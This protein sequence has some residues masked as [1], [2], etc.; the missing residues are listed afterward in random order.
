MS[1]SYANPKVSFWRMW[2]LPLVFI[3]GG[4][5]LACAYPDDAYYTFLEY[6]PTEHATWQPP[7]SVK[8]DDPLPVGEY[9]LVVTRFDHPIES[10]KNATGAGCSSVQVMTL[11]KVV[12]YSTFE[13]S[14]ED[15]TATTDRQWVN[16]GLFPC[17][18]Y[19]PL[20]SNLIGTLDPDHP[21]SQGSFHA[22][23]LSYLL[24]QLVKP[25]REAALPGHARLV[26]I[27]RFPSQNLSQ[28][29]VLDLWNFFEPDT[30]TALDL[31]NLRLAVRHAL[32]KTVGGDSLVVAFAHQIDGATSVQED[33]HPATQV[34]L[35]KERE[36]QQE[37]PKTVNT[38]QAE[39]K[40][41]NTLPNHP[42]SNKFTHSIN[43]AVKDYPDWGTPPSNARQGIRAGNSGMNVL[44]VF[45][46]IILAIVLV[47]VWRKR[48]SQQGETLAKDA[49][50]PAVT[51]RENP[52]S[53][54][55]ALVN[56]EMSVFVDD[57]A[58]RKRRIA[59]DTSF[60]FERL[61]TTAHWLRGRA[62]AIGAWV[63]NVGVST[64][65]IRTLVS[66][67]VAGIVRGS[68]VIVGYIR[69]LWCFIHATIVSWSRFISTVPHLEARISALEQSIASHMEIESGSVHARGTDQNALHT[70]ERAIA[71]RDRDMDQT[72]AR[73][74]HDLNSLE[75][76]VA[77]L[78]EAMEAH[79][80]V[81]SAQPT[82]PPHSQT[83]TLPTV[84]LP[85]AEVR[86]NVVPAFTPEVAVGR[87][88]RELARALL[89]FQEHQG[90]DA[91]HLVEGISSRCE[92]V[93]RW[94]EDILASNQ[95]LA[96]YRRYDS[97]I[98][99]ETN[100][101]IGLIVEVSVDLDPERHKVVA[102]ERIDRGTLNRVLVLV[103]PG[104]E[105]RG[106]VVRKAEV[107]VSR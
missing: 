49:D 60:F 13:M 43:D 56:A 106:H 28:Q 63:A 81:A 53:G 12:V 72:V 6:R 35:S 97:A 89:A 54:T 30:K 51:T 2:V 71:Q 52:S 4:G 18:S 75:R 86:S 47:R 84:Q 57:P 76:K 102:S 42:A 83:P 25:D 73:L 92:L 31:T 41:Q 50:H 64:H 107:V 5:H 90:Q 74:R 98:R 100:D 96:V 68:K 87:G 9:A 16:V 88:I 26:R 99:E 62:Q 40:D 3:L 37:P 69:R 27:H 44:L 80:R 36:K 58:Q 79:L 21:V 14:Y 85:L 8:T 24:H 91:E 104:V 38:N 33:T 15:H 105:C 103:R 19:A 66:I 23:E 59:H 101:R 39:N 65:T 55:S 77:Q 48:Q 45:S 94:V 20:T 29:Q 34:S 61:R 93:N 82:L 46:G 10:A 7:P 95:S 78:A 22:A 70:V 32:A 11:V 1:K 17:S 67:L